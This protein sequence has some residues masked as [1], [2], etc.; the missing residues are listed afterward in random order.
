MSYVQEKFSFAYTNSSQKEQP[1]YHLGYGVDD[2]YMR[3]LATSI[4]SFCANNPK[5]NL[6]FHIIT[7]GLHTQ[8]REKLK[9]LA[10]N[11]HTTIYLYTI[12]T[13]KLLTLPSFAHLPLATYFRFLFPL[14]LPQEKYIYYLD[15]DIVCLRDATNLFSINLEK[16][17]LVAAV[18]DLPWMNK[19]RNTA[20]SLENHT[21]FN[22]G[23]LIIN[24]PA[25]N[26]FKVMDKVL[27][28]LHADPKRYR[29]LDQ[30]ALNVLLTQKIY[31][32]PSIY[33]TI[34]YHHSAVDKIVL[35]HFAAHPKPWTVAW[36]IHIDKEDFAYDIYH[37]YEQMTP[38]KNSPLEYP[39]NY[40]D[41]KVYSKVLRKKGYWK[42]SL[43]WYWHY[44]LKKIAK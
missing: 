10:E 34:D 31:Y 14:I 30:D 40:K 13:A 23:L 9:E 38:W 21:Y 7:A 15:A 44:L 28:I 3:C 24:V 41:M 42:E 35:L 2:N 5:R 26:D 22:A 12:D 39:K 1:C 17:Y 36:N 43:I 11:L 8:N 19:K 29:Y 20:L 6:I 37:K 16:P 32:L 18:P 25:W 33:N 27:S 4:T